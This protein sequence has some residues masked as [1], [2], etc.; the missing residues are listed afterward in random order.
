M[1]AMARRSRPAL[2]LL[3]LGAALLLGGCERLRGAAQWACQAQGESFRYRDG[4]G[5]GEAGMQAIQFTLTTYTQRDGYKLAAHAVVPEL[6]ARAIV[7]DKA[8][9]N[10]VEWVYLHDS[11][12]ASTGFRTVSSLVLNSTSGDVRLF[13]HRWVPPVGWRDSDQYTFSGNCQ[14]KKG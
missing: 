4:Q 10:P 3:A 11:T 13:H 14:S 5:V 7:R 12:D 8:R 2:A 9:S 6:S 1:V